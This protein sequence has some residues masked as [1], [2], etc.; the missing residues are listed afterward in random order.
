MTPPH[1]PSNHRPSN[2]GSRPIASTFASLPAARPHAC[3]STPSR[4]RASSLTITIKP[5]F[6]RIPPYPTQPAASPW[7][8]SNRIHNPFPAATSA[9]GVRIRPENA[10]L[11]IHQCGRPL[12]G[13]PRR[14]RGQSRNLDTLN[15]L[16]NLDNPPPWFVPN[17]A[18]HMYW[19]FALLLMAASP[20]PK[21]L[22]RA[23]ESLNIEHHR[24]LL[25]Q[26][27]SCASPR[28][29]VIQVPPFPMLPSSPSSAEAEP[30][31]KG[32]RWAL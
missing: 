15:T 18:T 3:G 12:V 7:R 26:A 1:G 27:S 21:R 23:M 20:L 31:L 30:C 4:L 32:C 11:Q 24:S 5:P 6:L 10:R 13:C 14:I 25:V 9:K 17:R 22:L 8:S 28:R 29:E 19:G 16:D 2:Q